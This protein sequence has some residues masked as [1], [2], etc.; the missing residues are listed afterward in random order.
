MKTGMSDFGIYDYQYITRVG[1]HFIIRQQFENPDIVEV[2]NKRDL[3]AFL[4]DHSQAIIIIDLSFASLSISDV[5]ALHREFPSSHWIIFM[6]DAVEKVIREIDKY[7]F[8]SILLKDSPENEIVLALEYAVK[9]RRF[10]CK[11]VKDII[12]DHKYDEIP[13]LTHTEIEILKLLATG[14]T[15]KEIS[16]IRFSSVHTIITHKK[17]IFRKL[18]VKNIYEATKYAYGIGLMDSIEYYI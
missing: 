10:I 3:K 17:N 12:M 15:A 13:A 14:K 6:N 5:I 8:M 2:E 11:Q 9:N 4:H 16:A 18:G 1:L 7:P